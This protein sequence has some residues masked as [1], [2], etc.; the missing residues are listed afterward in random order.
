VTIASG[1]VLPNI[2][3]VLLPKKSAAAGTPAKAPKEKKEKA[4]KAA[5]EEEEDLGP[6]DYKPDPK[7]KDPLAALPKSS[8]N[9]DEWRRQYSNTK[10]HINAMPWFWQNFDAAGWSLWSMSYNY[11]AENKQGFMTSNAVEG[12]L[13]RC[14]EVRKYAF[15]QMYVLN[16]D[17]PYE[18][19]GVWLLRGLDTAPMLASNPDAE[20]YT[21]TKLD[22]AVPADKKLVEDYWSEVPFEG[23]LVGK[24]VYDQK[25]L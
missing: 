14:E 4:P 22:P 11:N 12:F 10:P 25:L 13:Q 16:K 21:W 2:H 20:Y 3:N 5:A 15:G 23:E 8:L 9:G 17:K 1:G 18:I 7:P 6:E 19:S 24:Y